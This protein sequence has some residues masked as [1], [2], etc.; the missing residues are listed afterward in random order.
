MREPR[1]L[2][3]KYLRGELAIPVPAVRRRGTGQKIRL[4]G[5]TEHNL[6]DVDITIPLN[7]L[8]CV[9]GV[10]GSGKSTLVHDVIYAAIKRAKGS[11]DKRVGHVQVARRRRVRHRRGARGSD[12]DR[13]DPA[14]ESGHLSQG[15]RSD[16]RAVCRD[17]RRASRAG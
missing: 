4:T 12:A 13:P 1:S 16:P 14:V 17:Q 3:S 8:T 10:S 7:T 6:K 2:T 11:W 15:V 5:A 9:T